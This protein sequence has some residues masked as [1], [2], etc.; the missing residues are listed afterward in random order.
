MANEASDSDHGCL[1]FDVYLMEHW[2]TND[3]ADTRGDKDEWDALA[4]RYLALT[5]MQ[6]FPYHERARSRRDRIFE[7]HRELF[8]RLFSTMQTPQDRRI[9]LRRSTHTSHDPIRIRTNYDASL[10]DTRGGAFIDKA[11][12]ACP[13]GDW[14]RVLLRMPELCDEMR[15]SS[16]EMHE[17]AEE[18]LAEAD[19]E[20]DRLTKRAVFRVYLVDGEALG[21]G[22]VKVLWLDCHGENVWENTIS[23]GEIQD[24]TGSCN[25]FAGV[26]EILQTFAEG[27]ERGARLRF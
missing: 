1:A 18:E 8:T 26:G 9:S 22:L 23:P 17:E 27:T 2:K 11:L 6:R 14:S 13:D 5:P 10:A 21:M 7:D 19:D 16:E 12:Y 20:M 15:F 24:F 25:A 3:P 4:R